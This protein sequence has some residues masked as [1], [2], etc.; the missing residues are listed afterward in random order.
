[1]L[2]LT[3]NMYAYKW[4]FQD[5]KILTS[6]IFIKTNL[7]KTNKICIKTNTCVNIFQTAH[8][9]TKNTAKGVLL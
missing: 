6:T 5:L 7:C 4:I 1:M 8:P 3:D 9:K 2:L